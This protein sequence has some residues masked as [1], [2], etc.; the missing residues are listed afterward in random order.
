MIITVYF[1]GCWS[2]NIGNAFIDYGALHLCEKYNAFLYSEYNYMM[3]KNFRRNYFNTF[4]DL[5]PR[6]VF[7]SG[8]VSCEQF[9]YDQAEIFEIID[10]NK[11]PV[12][13]NGIGGENFTSKEVLK[14][15]EFIKM[16]KIAGFI[17]RDDESFDAYADLF[18]P[19]M[20]HRGIDVAFFMVDIPRFKALKE[21]P[22]RYTIINNDDLGFNGPYLSFPE[23]QSAV[24]DGSI[25]Y[26]HHQL[27][28]M[29]IH[30]ISAPQT[31]L[32][33][34]PAEFVYL[35]GQAKTTFT[36]RVHACIAT[37]VFGGSC[38]LLYDTPRAKLFDRVGCGRVNKEFCKI[39]P[40]ILESKKAEHRHALDKIMEQILI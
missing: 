16:H 3:F 7:F 11:I 31:M 39:D 6:C 10:R 4:F 15:R 29:P 18:S 28:N 38:I 32:A 30:Y 35:Y 2:T 1:G 27:T 25:V 26:T 36:T 22:K 24:K 33:E 21:L 20:A 12:V 23:Y 13:F 9:I 8:M 37:L 40:L 19:N 5:N 17:S 14:F 34:L